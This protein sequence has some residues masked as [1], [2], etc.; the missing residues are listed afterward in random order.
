DFAGAGEGEKARGEID[1]AAV[2]VVGFDDDVADFEPHAEMHLALGRDARIAA[3][4]R[5]LDRESRRHGRAHVREVDQ[6]AVA[7]ALDDTAALLGQNAVPDM[8]HKS[9]PARDG[10]GLVLLD[11][12]HRFY[13]FDQEHSALRPHQRARKAAF[14]AGRFAV[15]HARLPRARA[16]PPRFGPRAGRPYQIAPAG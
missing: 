2:D 13:D 11:E 9:E 8:L 3:V 7:K 10:A 1:A 15:R 16:K 6:E 12:A 5:L 14:L 4:A